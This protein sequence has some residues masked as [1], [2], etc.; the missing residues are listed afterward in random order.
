MLNNNI[1]TI[2]DF[3]SGRDAF[4]YKTA[5]M[6]NSTCALNKDILFYS[7]ILFLFSGPYLM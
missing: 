5:Y 4:G 7:L 1:M 6:F 2:Y 3:F